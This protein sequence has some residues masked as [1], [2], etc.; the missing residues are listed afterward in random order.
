MS[1]KHCKAFLKR[2]RNRS[3]A[4]ALRSFDQ[5]GKLVGGS[6]DIFKHYLS[7]VLFCRANLLQ[8]TCSMYVMNLPA[9]RRLKRDEF[10]DQGESENCAAHFYTCLHGSKCYCIQWDFLPRKYRVA[11]L[12]F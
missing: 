12:T 1:M 5:A 3:L 7:C 4:G 8:P 2:I 6:P 11:V 9:L 10:F